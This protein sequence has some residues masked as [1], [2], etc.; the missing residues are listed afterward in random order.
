MQSQTE[1][2]KQIIIKYIFQENVDT[3]FRADANIKLH[4]LKN[5]AHKGNE[6]S[7]AFT[8]CK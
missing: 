2:L 8:I 5:D 7:A 4:R 6:N 1:I 3:V